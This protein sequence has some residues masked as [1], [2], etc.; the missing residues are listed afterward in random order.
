[1][2]R[3]R[4]VHWNAAEAQQRAQRL[5][6]AGYEVSYGVPE[7]QKSLRE[8]QENLPHAF[9]I[10]LERLPSQG[11]DLALFLRRHKAARYVPMV[12]VGGNPDKTERIRQSLKDATYT[13]WDHI[14]ADLAHAIANPPIDPLVPN[15]NLAGYS[16]APL[17]KK[18]GL[19]PGSVI[20]LVNAPSDFRRALG[21]LT[22]DVL[23]TNQATGDCHR[24]IWFTRSSSDLKDGLPKMAK[25]LSDR[26]G[27]WIAWPKKA[28]GV[29][30]DLS[31]MVVRESGLAAGLVD[32]KVCSINATW[33]GLLVSRRKPK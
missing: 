19:K 32:Y 17:P 9:V 14:E 5:E 27:L 1:M 31:D 21:P 4:L 18:L 26:G 11:R 16:G 20:A 7:G 30:S 6:S 29:K 12:L 23:I 10:D 22:E 8:L 2:P 25:V 15:S 33:S 28:S 24:I 13:T 3:V